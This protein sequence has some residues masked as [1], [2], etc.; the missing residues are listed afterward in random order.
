MGTTNKIINVLD[1]T[2]AQEAAT[3]NYVDTQSTNTNYLLKTGGTMTGNINLNTKQINNLGIPSQANDAATKNYVDTNYLLKTGGTMT[4]VLTLNSNLIVGGTASIGTSALNVITN[5]NVG[6]GTTTPNQKLEVAGSAIINN[7]LGV[8]G[9]ATIGTG[10]TITSGIVRIGG[11]NSDW[12]LYV[13]G[14]GNIGTL[15]IQGTAKITDATTLDSTLTVGGTSTLNG[16]TT[17]NNNLSV[18]GTATISGAGG[19]TISNANLIVRNGK[20]SIGNMGTAPPYEELN[21][22]GTTCMRGPLILKGGTID[23]NDPTNIAEIG[24]ESQNK[25]YTYIKFGG[26][27]TTDDW[28][29]L[30]QIS[31]YTTETE[32]IKFGLDFHNDSGDGGIDLRNVVSAPFGVAG[33]DTITTFFSATPLRGFY[34]PNG[35]EKRVNH[36][37]LYSFENN[38]GVTTLYSYGTPG[39]PTGNNSSLINYVYLPRGG[40]REKGINIEIINFTTVSLKVRS[41]DSNGTSTLSDI[42]TGTTTTASLITLNINTKLKL[43]WDSSNWIGETYS[44]SLPIV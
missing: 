23:E 43:T 41:V 37:D 33:T 35:L 30:R 24:V 44:I 38:P 10:L 15:G 7:D 29:Y 5:G 8:S 1:P 13:G 9:S 18:N 32:K 21:V 17:V 6:I 14:N 4:G 40:S 20:V 25:T 27:G 22:Y 42:I 19:L 34:N 31:K 28:A 3:K 2:S 11:T 39:P 16:V 26:N 12:K 36:T